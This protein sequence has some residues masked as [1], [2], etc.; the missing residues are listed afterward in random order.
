MSLGNGTNGGGT[1]AMPGSGAMP[2]QPATSVPPAGAM[3][4]PAA[5]GA[6][7]AP[8]APAVT[9]PATGEDQLGVA[10]HRAL[11]AERQARRDAEARAQTLE[12]ERDALRTATQTDAEKAL[13]QAKRDAKAEER[14]IWQSHIRTSEVRSTLRAAGLSNE[15]TLALA[16]QAPEFAKLRVGEDGTVEKLTETVAQFRK[17]YPELFAAPAA[18]AAPAPGGAWDGSAGGGKAPATNL[19]DAVSAHYSKT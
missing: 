14:G 15:K 13:E 1:G 4:G 11:E 16:V 7:P 19:E 9:T 5:A 3:P 12:Q 2:G 6:P 18:P 8:A 17:D 10:G